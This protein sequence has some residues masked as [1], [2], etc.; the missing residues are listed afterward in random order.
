M[1]RWIICGI[2]LVLQTLRIAG[3]IYSV[4]RSTFISYGHVHTYYGCGITGGTIG[5]GWGYTESDYG[6][7]VS[8]NPWAR[9]I[10]RTRA[11]RGKCPLGFTFLA[12]DPPRMD[13]HFIALP[14][15]FLML[16]SAIGL[17]IV[18]L[19]TARPS[20]KGAFPVELTTDH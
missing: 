17:V 7:H 20:P 12:W 8:V 19:K 10:L 6:W 15:W 18:W 9:Q 16:L 14:F 2:F 4:P 1:K 11:I 13:H 3:W 5:L